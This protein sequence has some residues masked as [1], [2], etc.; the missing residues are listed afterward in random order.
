LDMTK[1]SLGL[2]GLLTLPLG[3]AAPVLAD[4]PPSAAVKCVDVRG[5]AY[6][7]LGYDHRVHLTNNCKKAVSCSVK[8]DVNPTVSQV[9]LAPGEKQTVITWRGSPASE[10]KPD[11]KCRE[12]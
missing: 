2:L 4:P 12:R 8:T 1:R 9:D 11:V 3:L 6:Y 7:I 10:F 5:E